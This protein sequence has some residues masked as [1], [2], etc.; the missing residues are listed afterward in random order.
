M[1]MKIPMFDN[2][3]RYQ[4]LDNE[5]RYQNFDNELRYQKMVCDEDAY[6]W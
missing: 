5:L 3:L 4:K 6:V 2:E 1:M